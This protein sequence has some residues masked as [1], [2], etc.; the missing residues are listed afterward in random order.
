MGIKQ[1]VCGTIDSNL[2]TL[3][4][5]FFLSVFTINFLIGQAKNLST[6]LPTD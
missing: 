2:L 4:T 5:A 1:I 3:I 6:Y